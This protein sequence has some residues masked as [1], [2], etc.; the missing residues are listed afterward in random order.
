MSPGCCAPLAALTRTIASVPLLLT[1][2]ASE[3][4]T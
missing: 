3:R 4:A 2:S 1:R